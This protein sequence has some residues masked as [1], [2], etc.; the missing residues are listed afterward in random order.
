MRIH[1]LKWS[2]YPPPEVQ[3]GCVTIGNFDGVHRGHAALVKTAK[4]LA[5][6]VGGPAVA[7][8]FD[9]PPVAL[10]NPPAWK[11]PLATLDER[12]KR[13]LLAG[14]DHVVILETDASLLALAAE[15]FFED[16]LV[17][18]LG[19]KAIVE[20]YNFHF[21]RGRG[22]NVS[23]LRTM[24]TAAGIAFE[25]VPPLLFEGEAISSSRVRTAVNAGDVK[26]AAELLGYPYRIWGD[27]VEGAKRGRT[28]GFP[29]ANLANVRTLPPADGVYAVRANSLPAAANVGPNPTFGEDARKI[30]VHLL[31]FTGDLYGTV[32][33]VEFVARLRETKPFANV[34]TLKA[35][36]RQDVAA[37]LEVLAR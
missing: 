11:L 4:Q 13:L 32:M 24:C 19:V 12:V 31:D 6:S 18:Q 35:Q 23:T 17:R 14:A 27:V 34:E 22:G 28:I 7:V 33:Q 20:G 30:E 37:T 5:E 16:V 25:E 9:P 29:T 26:R 3:G 36:L 2:E 8:T 15:A 21:G 1:R 10:L